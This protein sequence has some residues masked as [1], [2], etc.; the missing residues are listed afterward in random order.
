MSDS[1]ENNNSS[2]SEPTLRCLRCDTMN[3][4]TQQRCAGCGYLL[5]ASDDSAESL[6][7]TPPLSIDF[8]A[9]QPPSPPKR[10]IFDSVFPIVAMGLALI[11]VGLGLQLRQQEQA[12][13]AITPPPTATP[14]ETPT[15]FIT[16]APTLIPLPTQTATRPPTATPTATATPL[17]TPTLEPP[18]EYTIADGE[19]ML[20]IALRY[21][22][23][24]DSIVAVN[25]GLS[26]ERI[27]SGQTILVP[28]PT[29]TPPLTAVEVV[30]NG[31]TVIADPTDCVIHEIQD[32][33]TYSGIAGRYNVPLD[34][35]V[36]MNR[37]SENSIL[38]P[39]D[40][41]CIPTITIAV[42]SVDEASG[43]VFSAER[44]VPPQPQLLF[45]PENGVVDTQAV[46]LQW[47]ADRDL[48][49]QEWYMIEV[50]NLTDLTAR[51]FRAFVQQTSF[52]LPETLVAAE[53]TYRW[54][55]SYVL[56]SGERTDGEFI[57]AFGGPS[58][59]S[60][61]SISP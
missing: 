48:G 43:G 16:E 6:E 11:A 21:R 30:F 37:L 53:A 34:A 54:R 26:P 12:V 57:Y 46:T 2:S 19:V 28:R 40:Q 58:S 51:P 1:A 45:P 15:V 32:A 29:A 49:I 33:D 8:S 36:A 55:V 56:V 60:T 14:T 25:E 24:I 44:P 61:F 39:G 4:A 23:S 27:V 47:I 20:N 13:A 22:V 10:T 52:Q 7:I 18:V 59:E 9:S 50:T 38:Q 31:E 42:T 5:A 17:P 35:L 41:V 3:S